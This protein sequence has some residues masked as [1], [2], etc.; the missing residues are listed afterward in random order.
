MKKEAKARQSEVGCE[1]GRVDGIEPCPY[2]FPS[3]GPQHLTAIIR[4]SCHPADHPT[5]SATNIRT[6]NGMAGAARACAASQVAADLC[7]C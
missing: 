4:V 2:T 6:S 1:K 3:T 7:Q 5:V